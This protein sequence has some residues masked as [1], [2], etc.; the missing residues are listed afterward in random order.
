MKKKIIS[1]VLAGVLCLSFAACSSNDKSKSNKDK[2]EKRQNKEASADEDLDEEAETTKETEFDEEAF[3]R[4]THYLLDTFSEDELL[5]FVN[6]VY[7]GA[8]QAGD[9]T[10][11][12]YEKVTT[13]VGHDA[14]GY[15]LYSSGGDIC[16]EY[17]NED[18]ME[19]D[20]KWINGRDNVCKIIY[21]GYEL[22][23]FD[24]LT[25]EGDDILFVGNKESYTCPGMP[26]AGTV[27]FHFYD[28]DR[29]VQAYDILCSYIDSE[30]PDAEKK[31][32]S[33][34]K[35]YE[36]KAMCEG[37]EKDHYATAFEMYNEDCKCWV[38]QFTARFPSIG[39]AQ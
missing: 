20:G 13:S 32:T 24:M 38:V 21:Y 35:Y 3:M 15:G 25:D 23:D 19:L 6:A 36:Y 31:D 26:G 1:A 9:S 8:P 34:S 30:Y 4:Q 22:N 11:A 18:E 2:T 33:T 39:E 12:V 37:S 28:E 29:A 27:E 10:N 17:G 7:D 14:A 5:K 16:I